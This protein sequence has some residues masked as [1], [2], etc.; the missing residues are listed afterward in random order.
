[1]T[2]LLADS[3]ATVPTGTYGGLVATAAA[4]STTTTTWTV[5][6]APAT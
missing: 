4:A 1:V 6:L 5:I 2:T 3:A